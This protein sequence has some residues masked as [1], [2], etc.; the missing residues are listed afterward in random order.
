MNF[1]L[2]KTFVFFIFSS[3]LFLSYYLGVAFYDIT[4][5]IDFGKYIYNLNLFYQSSSIYN[6]QGTFYFWTIYK[7]SGLDQQMFSDQ[8]FSTLVNNRLQL[9]NFLYYLI[10]LSGILCLYI[11]KNFKIENILISLTILNFFPACF[12]LRLTMKPEIMA[13]ALLPWLL[14]FCDFYLKETT[15]LKTFLLSIF[16]S[17]V[18]TI[19]ASITG[20]IL[21]V[22]VLFYKEEIK[23]LRNH[24][25][26]IFETFISFVL[27]NIYIFFLTEK[28][29]FARQVEI[30][31]SLS[32]KWDNTATFSFFTNIDFKNLYE[33]P[34][35]HIHSESFFSITLLDTIGDYFTFFWKHEEDGNFFAKDVIK[36]T[37]NFLIQEYISEYIS[38]IFTFIFYFIIL[39]L[40]FK[41]ISNKEFLLLPFCGLIVLILNSLGFPNKNFDPTTGDLFKVHYY[42][43]LISISFSFLL[44]YFFQ[45]IRYVK[46]LSLALIPVFL[47]TIGFPKQISEESLNGLI[48]KMEN[49]NICKYL[50][51]FYESECA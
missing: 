23:N 13:F 45:K 22:L 19:K 44:N 29:L 37:E 27:L 18:L 25:V 49:T 20:M 12:Y 16:L 11:R 48:T 47:L 51:Y 31:E 1:K 6:S 4:N 10:G 15:T 34:F 38:I 8:A 21:L 43:F 32:S 5:G 46:F 7:F 35:K 14:L 26:L 33:N 9:V 36:F 50:D 30:D 2:R 17:I 41:G 3:T 24:F 28:W 39:A 40:Y 42:A